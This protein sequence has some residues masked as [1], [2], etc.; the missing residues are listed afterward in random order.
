MLARSDRF[1]RAAGDVF[2]AAGFPITLELRDHP[3][4]SIQP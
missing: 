3:F 2:P 1:E 4:R